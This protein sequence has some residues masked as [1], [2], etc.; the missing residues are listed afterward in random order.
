[1]SARSKELVE[2]SVVSSRVE[3]ERAKAGPVSLDKLMD[4]MKAGLKELKI[5]LKADVQGSVEA[6]T[7]CAATS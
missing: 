3:K 7:S 4:A 1:M 2:F 5:I 6:L